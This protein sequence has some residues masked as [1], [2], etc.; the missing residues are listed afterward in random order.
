MMGI[1]GRTAL[2]LEPTLE[3]RAERVM[4]AIRRVKVSPLDKQSLAPPDADLFMFRNFGKHFEMCHLFTPNRSANRNL[5]SFHLFEEI[6]DVIR[7]YYK[8]HIKEYPGDKTVI[9]SVYDSS[10]RHYQNYEVNISAGSS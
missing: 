8:W 9:A 4:R 10:L 5:D 3:A 2:R 7:A 6:P 1:G